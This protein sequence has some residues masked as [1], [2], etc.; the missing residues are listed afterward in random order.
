ME[1]GFCGLCRE[2]S[3]NLCQETGLCQECSEEA[4][5]YSRYDPYEHGPFQDTREEHNGER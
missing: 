3:F 2:W 4:E 5:P 1:Q